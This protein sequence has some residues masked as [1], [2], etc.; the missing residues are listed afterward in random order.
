MKASEL[1]AAKC[2]KVSSL[3]FMMKK[4]GRDLKGNIEATSGEGFFVSKEDF[5]PIPSQRYVFRETEE[6]YLEEFP[7]ESFNLIV[8][9]QE[10]AE[11]KIEKIMDMANAACFAIFNDNENDRT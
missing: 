5:H 3:M 2:Y 6:T 4:I 9:I 10:K 1:Q 11:A 8:E 7:I